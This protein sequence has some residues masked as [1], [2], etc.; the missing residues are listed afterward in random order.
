MYC[1]ITC[2]WVYTFENSTHYY[3]LDWAYL[4]QIKKIQIT[5]K[6]WSEHKMF[7]PWHPW[8]PL[9]RYL[10]WPY[11][12]ILICLYFFW[13]YLPHWGQIMTSSVVGGN[14]CPWTCLFLVNCM[15]PVQLFLLFMKHRR[16][17]KFAQVSL[18]WDNTQL[19]W[20]MLRIHYVIVKGL[21][22]T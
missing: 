5:E 22:S 10:L 11:L 4:W 1:V 20:L 19:C 17:Q 16:A 12:W 9:Y 18:H 6:E 15:A 7:R 8:K 3:L 2:A 14:I 13:S 21:L